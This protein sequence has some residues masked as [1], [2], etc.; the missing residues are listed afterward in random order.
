MV[1][2]MLSDAHKKLENHIYL[3]GKLLIKYLGFLL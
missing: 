1:Y 3:F 2:L